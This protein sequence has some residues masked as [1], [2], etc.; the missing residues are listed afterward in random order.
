MMSS[1]DWM[2]FGE[3]PFNDLSAGCN[4]NLCMVLTGYYFIHVVQSQFR[5]NNENESRWE[6]ILGPFLIKLMGGDAYIYVLVLDLRHCALL[7][8]IPALFG[9]KIC[10]YHSQDEIIT[11]NDVHDELTNGRGTRRN[12]FCNSV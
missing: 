9:S 7:V 5:H 4:D 6:G 10:T 11:H 3:E 1:L 8:F 12:R 2:G